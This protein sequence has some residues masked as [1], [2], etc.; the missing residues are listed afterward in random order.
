MIDPPAG[1]P[2]AVKLSLRLRYRRARGCARR[3]AVLTLAGTGLDRVLRAGLSFRSKR[4]AAD[5][6]RPFRLAVTKKRL[7]G[8]RR[9]LVKVGVRLRGGRL[10]TVT[11]RVRG[12][13]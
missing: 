8:R 13:C 6:S 10:V 12:L 2:T 1:K 5:R 9:G 3:A 11:R 7:G 4:L